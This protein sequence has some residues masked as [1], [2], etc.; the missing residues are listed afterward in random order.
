ML[1]VN[2]YETEVVFF[3]LLTILVTCLLTA[4]LLKVSEYISKMMVIEGDRNDRF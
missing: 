2:Y 3:I 1:N 4:S